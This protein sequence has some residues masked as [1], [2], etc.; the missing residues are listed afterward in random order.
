MIKKRKQF[1]HHEIK[2]HT[3]EVLEKQWEQSKILQPQLKLYQI[4]SAT[5]ESG[6]LDNKDVLTKLAS[7]KAEGVAIGLSLSG[8]QQ[9]EVLEGKKALDLNEQTQ[10]MS[11]PKLVLVILLFIVFII[12]KNKRFSF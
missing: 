7:L 12:F 10:R 4:H 2:R 11:E 3:L 8:P 5:F 9:K 6:V 1:L